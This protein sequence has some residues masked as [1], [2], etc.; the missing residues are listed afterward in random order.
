MR[1]NG[2]TKEPAGSRLSGVELANRPGGR[3]HIARRRGAVRVPAISACALITV[4][5]A[6]GCSDDGDD[7]LVVL[8]GE[9]MAQAEFDGLRL[10]Q[11]TERSADEE[12]ATGKPT[13]ARITRI[14]EPT[15]R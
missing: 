10:V 13:Y 9:S 1:R 3:S 5:A 6:V 11:E 7:D 15:G 12:G 14:F 2:P 4:M 8:R